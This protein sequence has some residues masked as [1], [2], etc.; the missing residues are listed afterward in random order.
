VKKILTK[1]KSLDII[2]KCENEQQ[3]NFVCFLFVLFFQFY[4]GCAIED[5]QQ[6]R[7]QWKVEGVKP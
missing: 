2:L 7:A 1:K 6:K 3:I 5:M 4:A